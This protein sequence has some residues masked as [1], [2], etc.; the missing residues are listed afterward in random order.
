MINNQIKQFTDEKTVQMKINKQKN[1]PKYLL[2]QLHKLA[3][4]STK[5]LKW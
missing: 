3:Q 2:K 1:A 4:Y 5:I